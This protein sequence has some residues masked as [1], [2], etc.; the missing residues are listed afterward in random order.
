MGGAQG[1]VAYIDTEGAL[2]LERRSLQG[3][4]AERCVGT[5]RPDRIRAI[6]QR[7]GVDGDLALDNIVYGALAPGVSLF[8]STL[9]RSPGVQQ[10]APGTSF[11]CLT[12]LSSLNLLQMELV[13]ELSSRFAEEK[14]FRLLVRSRFLD[15]SDLKLTQPVDCRQHYGLFPHRLLWPRRAQRETAEGPSSSRLRAQQRLTSYRSL[16]KSVSILQSS[17]LGSGKEEAALTRMSRRCS[18]SSPRCR[19]STTFVSLSPA[20][21]DSERSTLC[22][23]PSS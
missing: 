11:M 15:A 13:N 5:F 21:A 16:D 6:A 17:P 20:C 19:R 22:S 8:H 10:R 9:L 14:D 18:T 2:P 1:K 12:P 7:F 3:V 23:S 4:H